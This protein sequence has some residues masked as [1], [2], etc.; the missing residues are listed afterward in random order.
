MSGH[1]FLT[2]QLCHNFNSFSHN[3]CTGWWNKQNHLRSLTVRHLPILRKG[4][5]PREVES[6]LA[7]PH[8]AVASGFEYICHK[9]KDGTVNVNKRNI[10][11]KTLNEAKQNRQNQPRRENTKTYLWKFKERWPKITNKKVRYHF[12]QI[13]WYMGVQL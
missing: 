5:I 12:V 7:D 13:I 11:Q 1:F 9:H 4:W 3:Y 2:C 10:L 6:A 8:R